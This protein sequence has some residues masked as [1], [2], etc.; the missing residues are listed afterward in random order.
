MTGELTAATPE[1]AFRHGSHR[2][3]L[4]DSDMGIETVTVYR[5]TCQ[6]CGKAL[7][8][9][10]WTDARDHGWAEPADG[11]MQLCPL[12]LEFH[13]GQMLATAVTPDGRPPDGC[14]PDPN[15]R[16]AK[17]AAAEIKAEPQGTAILSDGK[18]NT[19]IDSMITLLQEMSWATKA[20]GGLR[21]RIDAIYIQV[22]HLQRHFAAERQRGES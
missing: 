16:I 5:V 21:Q 10:K 12:C 4:E 1:V 18:I 3:L 22:S 14:N 2:G 20:A 13:R 17:T 15:D 6:R 19:T 8:V 7:L 11:Q 9:D